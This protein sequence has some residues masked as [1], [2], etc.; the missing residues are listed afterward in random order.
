MLIWEGH[1]L[2]QKKRTKNKTITNKKS[3][4]GLNKL[5]E[6]Y[7]STKWS[8]IKTR[9][10]L[11]VKSRAHFIAFRGHDILGRAD[12]TRLRSK[13]PNKCSLTSNFTLILTLI[14]QIALV[15]ELFW[16]NS[17][18]VSSLRVCFLK[19]C[20][21]LCDFMCV[22]VSGYGPISKD[23]IDNRKPI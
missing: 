10:V 17:S 8:G 14:G 20:G 21:R 3:Q 15:F 18:Y 6:P 23:G 13:T 9:K 19:L 4:T 11:T 16:N 7:S 2:G 22:W 5:L 1:K 12:K